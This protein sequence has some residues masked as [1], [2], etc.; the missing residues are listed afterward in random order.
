MLSFENP[1]R[2][3]RGKKNPVVP[4]LPVIANN[5]VA[6]NVDRELEE[7]FNLAVNSTYP[8]FMLSAVIITFVVYP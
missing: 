5:V 3:K 6:N 7:K 1:G 8:M 4:V 2:K